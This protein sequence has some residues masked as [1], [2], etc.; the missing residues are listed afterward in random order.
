VVLNVA[1]L[2][3]DDAK[4][5]NHTSH[6]S[7]RQARGPTAQSDSWQKA[8]GLIGQFAVLMRVV[9]FPRC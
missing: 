6:R 7:E 9:L 8:A 3:A 1:V 5:L 2:V 4:S